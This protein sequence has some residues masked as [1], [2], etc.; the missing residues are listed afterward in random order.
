LNSQT[1]LIRKK[2]VGESV[3][4]NLVISEEDAVMLCRTNQGRK[5]RALREITKYRR[6]YNVKFEF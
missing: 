3:V 4:G 1:S 2:I 6:V 5:T